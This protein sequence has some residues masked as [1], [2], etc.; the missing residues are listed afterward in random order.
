MLEH[1]P[2]HQE[3]RLGGG[4]RDILYMLEHRPLHQD[5]RRNTR[6]ERASGHLSC[7]CWGIGPCI[8]M[9]G[10]KKNSC[11]SR[12]ALHCNDDAA[13]G[14]P[15]DDPAK[16]SELLWAVK[17]ACTAFLRQGRHTPC[18]SKQQTETSKPHDMH[19]AMVPFFFSSSSCI[20]FLVRSSMASMVACSQSP[21]GRS[22]QSAASQ[23]ARPMSKNIA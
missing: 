7:T 1:R 13:G 4:N 6:R 21:A 12:V 15:V 3:L 22:S 16:G 11:A 10:A 14:W 20:S 18:A 17:P 5:V 8:R 2:L 9:S 23:P 19:S